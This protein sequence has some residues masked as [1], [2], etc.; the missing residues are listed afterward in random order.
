MSN[1]T[2]YR[3]C[4]HGHAGLATL[5]S[6][7]AR[8]TRSC[9]SSGTFDD[10]LSGALRMSGP[11]ATGERRIEDMWLETFALPHNPSRCSQGVQRPSW[12]PTGRFDSNWRKRRVQ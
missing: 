11:N 9:A 1:V 10:P 7:P 8:A 6:S 3:A 5:S 2:A 12:T 4:H